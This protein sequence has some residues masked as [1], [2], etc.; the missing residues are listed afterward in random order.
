MLENREHHECQ[1]C[2]MELR[3]VIPFREGGQAFEWVPL[4]CS[5]ECLNRRRGDDGRYENAV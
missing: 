3:E 5:M 1:A 4:P 2:R